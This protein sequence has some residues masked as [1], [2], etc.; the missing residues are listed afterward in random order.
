MV[1]KRIDSVEQDLLD[2][3]TWGKK[4]AKS[5]A[6]VSMALVVLLT[7]VSCTAAAP[8][9]TP[10]PPTP[11][12]PTGTPTSPAKSGPRSYVLPTEDGA[13]TPP[14]SHAGEMPR[15]MGTVQIKDIGEFTFDASQVET[16]RPDIFQPGHFSLFDIL[17]HLDQRG[18]IQLDYHFDED[19]D[20]HVIDAING[21]GGWWYGAHYSGGW[22]ER[23]VFRM[24][25][26]PYKNGTQ[27]RLFRESEEHLT[28]IYRTFQDE[29]ARLAGNGG[30]VI[31]PEVTIESPRRAWTFQDV[32]VT[33]H[34]ARSDMLQPGVVTALD[35]LLSLAE[36]GELS[37]I[38]LTWY[39]RIGTAD[40]VDTYYVEQIGEAEA[41]GSCGFVYETGPQAFSGFTGSHIHIPSDIRVTVSP[42]YALWFWIC[43]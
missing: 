34:D 31:I 32:V 10:I 2:K 22:S 11:N 25:T 7:V 17:F 5:S 20:T 14:A 40:P 12:V 13:W 42:E 38:K 18:D 35:A 39:E 24:D 27:I 43:L 3:L 41:Y 15:G 4:H 23:N 29:V 8:A 37:Q 33:A 21:Q 1:L 16:L 36:Q 6:Y 26:Y 30:Q 9:D 19:M 28:A